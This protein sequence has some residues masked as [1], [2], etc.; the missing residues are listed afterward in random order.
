MVDVDTTEMVEA[1]V[2]GDCNGNCQWQRQR[3]TATATATE[4]ESAT[5]MEMA[6]AIAMATATARATITRE[7]LP[8]H[9]PAMCSAVAGATPCLHPHGHKGECTHQ[10]CIMGVTLLRVFAPL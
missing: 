8:L 2:I 4:I 9:V 3:L 7:G 6:M 1:M 5:V 10:R